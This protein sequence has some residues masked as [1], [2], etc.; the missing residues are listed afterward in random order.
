[1]T[2]SS[3]VFLVLWLCEFWQTLW[4]Q[5]AMCSSRNVRFFGFPWPLRTFGPTLPLP[6]PTWCE[7]DLFFS[8]VFS[9]VSRVLV[10]KILGFFLGFLEMVENSRVFRQNQGFLENFSRVFYPR[11]FLGQNPKCEK[12]VCIHR[13]QTFTFSFFRTVFLGKYGFLQRLSCLS[14][15]NEV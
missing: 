15:Q 1:M 3:L 14:G 6:T 7:P 10:L 11:M 4:Y 12:K 2:A 5:T 9:R 13:S 8:R